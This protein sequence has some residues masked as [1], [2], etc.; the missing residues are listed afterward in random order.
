MRLGAAAIP[1]LGY[2]QFCHQ[3][4][5]ECAGPEPAD[6]P[7][8]ADLAKADT[9]PAAELASVS[10]TRSRAVDW[11]SDLR[12]AWR[13]QPITI[14]LEPWSAEARPEAATAFDLPPT[15]PSIIMRALGGD[16]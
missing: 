1:P 4:P 3:R 8:A 11:R 2:L 12:L 10:L 15:G 7:S 14:R 16:S 9:A 6:A 13:A 5:E